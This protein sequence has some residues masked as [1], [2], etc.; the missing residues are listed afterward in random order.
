MSRIQSSI[1]K[2]KSTHAVDDHEDHVIKNHNYFV[3]TVNPGVINIHYCIFDIFK[4]H[5]KAE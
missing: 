2:L 4:I 1:E 3:N 5:F